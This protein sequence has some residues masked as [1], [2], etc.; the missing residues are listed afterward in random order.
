VFSKINIY[1]YYETM[2]ILNYPIAFWNLRHAIS[3]TYWIRSY[4]YFTDYFRPS[5][6][7][8]L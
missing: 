2:D 7:K 6:K 5:Y 1:I 4:D 8:N 3:F